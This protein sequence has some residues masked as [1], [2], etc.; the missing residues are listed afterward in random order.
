LND[1]GRLT[2]LFDLPGNQKVVDAAKK[3]G[4]KKFVLVSSILTNGAAIGQFFNPAYLVLNII[5]GGV[6]VRDARC[7]PCGVVLD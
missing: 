3:K 5:G 1:H 2:S 4:V 7:P 6:L